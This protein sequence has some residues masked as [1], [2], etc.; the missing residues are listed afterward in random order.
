MTPYD[1]QALAHKGTFALVSRKSGKAICEV[2]A[3]TAQAADR[4]LYEVVTILSWLQRFNRLV[5]AAGGQPSRE[6]FLAA[7]ES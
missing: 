5:K 3:V 4:N 6:Q 1:E 7:I 2:R